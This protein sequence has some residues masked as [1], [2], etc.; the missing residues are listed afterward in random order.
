MNDNLRQNWREARFHA[1]QNN[2]IDDIIAGRRRTALQRLADRYRRFS[3][4]ALIMLL[5]IPIAFRSQIYPAESR[6][7]LSIMFGVYFLLC[8]GID[9]WLYHG[10][11]HIDCATMPVATVSELA[12]FYRRRH[13]QSIILLVP[14]A[15]FNVGMMVYYL[16]D[17]EWMIAAISAGVIIGLALG[18][19]ALLRFM[20]DYRDIA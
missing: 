15:I 19:R 16:T 2:S 9:R 11:S 20:N 17:D 4:I 3:N 13:L 14:L 5:C 10:I 6:L 7:P 8:S 18:I 1:P 12:L